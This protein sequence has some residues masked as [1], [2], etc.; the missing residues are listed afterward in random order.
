MTQKPLNVETVEVLPP[1]KCASNAHLKGGNDD[2]T[3]KQLTKLFAEAQTGMRRVIALGLFAWEIKEGHLKHGQFG[4][5]LAEHCP[6]LATVDSTTGK[7]KP[8]RALQGYMAMTKNVLES[9][10]FATIE[11]YLDEAAK[12]SGTKNLSHGGFL[13]VADKKVPESVKPLR[14]KICQLV[15]GK[16]AKQ[17]NLQFSQM[18]ED[19]ENPKPKRGQLKGSKGLT[20][21]MREAAAL[22]AE[23]ERI[24]ELELEVIDMTKRLDEITD[25]K[26]IGMMPDKVLRKFAERAQAAAAFATATLE[27]RKAGG[28]K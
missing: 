2:A 5:W 1:V 11:K 13:L 17:L 6:K 26:N 19:D 7:A 22:K 28:A 4:P 3:A 14:E 12:F 18:D 25:A 21:E 10:G 16:T 23:Q 15:D 27:A 24:N 8:S 9:V 20:K